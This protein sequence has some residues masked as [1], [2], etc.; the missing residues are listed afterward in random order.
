MKRILLFTL[1]ASMA[2]AAEAPR[3]AP[4]GGATFRFCDGL[5]ILIHNPKGAAFTLGVDLRD[6]NLFENGP[7][8]VLLKVYDPE[9]KALVRE[10]IPDDGVVTPVSQSPTGGWDHEGWYSLYQNNRGAPP[11]LKWS[12]LAASD[13]LA[14]VPARVIERKIPAGAP[15]AYRVVM[16]GTRD[17]VASVRV[18]PALS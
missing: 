8:E 16:V 10:V 6:L 3:L 2:V 1:L 17:H 13:R 18:D 4:V 14:A 11:M 5:T 7:R 15:G 12:G 9:G